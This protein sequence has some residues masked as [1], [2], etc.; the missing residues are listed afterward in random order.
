MNLN[1]KNEM[2]D[3]VNVTLFTYHHNRW[4]K[5]G[6][7]PVKRNVEYSALRHKISI[8]GIAKDIFKLISSMNLAESNS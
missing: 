2:G 6:F 3:V 8:I 5:F 1:S 7:G 4:F